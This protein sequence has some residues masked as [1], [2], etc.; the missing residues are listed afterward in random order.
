CG[1]PRGAVESRAPVRV[2]WH[3]LFAA[4]RDQAFAFYAELFGWQRAPAPSGA[5]LPYQLFAA[6]GQ[7]LGGMFTKPPTDPAPYWYFY[8]NV[9]DI[10]DAVARI[11]S[12]G[13]RVFEGPVD[14]PGDSWIARCADPQGAAF[15][16]QGR[17]REP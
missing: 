1:S 4:D 17:R 12:A 2:G 9:G 3:D 6:G 16:L 7:T 15:A 14:A 11:K 13:G 8:F 10:D 5:A